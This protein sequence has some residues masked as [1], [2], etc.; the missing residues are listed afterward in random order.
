VFRQAARSPLT[1][2][3]RSVQRCPSKV[4]SDTS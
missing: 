4:A 2:S 3:G 1:G